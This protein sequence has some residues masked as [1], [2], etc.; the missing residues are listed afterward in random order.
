MGGGARDTAGLDVSAWGV[1][2]GNAF[3]RA[4]EVRLAPVEAD[5]Q[6]SAREVDDDLAVAV[7]GGGDRDRARPRRRRLPHA[8]LPNPRR[9]LSRAVDTHDLHVRPLGKAR[10]RL[11]ARSNPSDL[12]R[13]AADD[14]VRVAHGNRYELDAV[15]ALRRTGADRAER[16]LDVP[17]VLPSRLDVTLSDAH[18]R[19]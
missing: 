6:V 10:I 8:A 2:S 3:G 16:L 19:R 12:V 18:R 17:V 14:C 1:L 7:R 4:R 13:I 15:D 5:A 11:E 9:H